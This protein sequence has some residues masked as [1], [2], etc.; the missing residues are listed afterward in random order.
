MNESVAKM[1]M[2]TRNITDCMAVPFRN[3]TT[4]A[5]PYPLWEISIRKICKHK[6]AFLSFVRRKCLCGCSRLLFILFHHSTKLIHQPLGYLL[7]TVVDAYFLFLS[8]KFISNVLNLLCIFIFF[9]LVF[10]FPFISFFAEY[11]VLLCVFG[12][13]ASSPKITAKKEIHSMEFGC[14]LCSVQFSWMRENGSVSIGLWTKWGCEKRFI[15]ITKAR[16]VF[17][18][19]RVRMPFILLYLSLH[20]INWNNRTHQPNKCSLS[21]S[22]FISSSQSHACI[23][24][25]SFMPRH[26]C[27]CTNSIRQLSWQA[28]VII[29]VALFYFRLCRHANDLNALLGVQSFIRFGIFF[30]S[31]EH[32]FL[33]NNIR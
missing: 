10:F 20:S 5:A 28:Q 6:S 26:K 27:S 4:A 33:T 9:L 23:S 11:L 25:H 29:H 24:F 19:K 1:K 14:V 2:K 32:S 31:I 16:N 17:I 12:S 21:F 8:G 13:F 30:L 7:Y 3:E 18:E 15:E 22:I